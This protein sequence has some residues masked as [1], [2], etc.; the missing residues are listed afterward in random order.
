VLCGWQNPKLWE[1]GAVVLYAPCICD[2]TGEAVDF[3]APPYVEG[4]RDADL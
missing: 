3:N 4:E 1:K 2:G